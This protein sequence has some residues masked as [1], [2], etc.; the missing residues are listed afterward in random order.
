MYVYAEI[1]LKRKT[2]IKKKM[3]LIKFKHK[4]IQFYVYSIQRND[5]Q[6]SVCVCWVRYYY[7][8]LFII[9]FIV[10]FFLALNTKYNAVCGACPA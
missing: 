7:Y 8:F 1:L 3:Y 6:Q 9:S 2:K 10:L 5:C 4:K